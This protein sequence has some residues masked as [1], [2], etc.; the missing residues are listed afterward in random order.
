MESES[1]GRP[2]SR[3]SKEQRHNGQVSLLLTL[4]F[5]YIVFL[6]TFDPTAVDPSHLV[7]VNYFIGGRKLGIS[8]VGSLVSC[9]HSPSLSDTVRVPS[10]ALR[11]SNLHLIDVAHPYVCPSVSSF[12]SKNLCLRPSRRVCK[13]CFSS[14]KMLCVSAGIPCLIFHLSQLVTFIFHW[15]PGVRQT[16]LGAVS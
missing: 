16:W 5:V 9:T 1:P 7:L 10:P 14:L 2:V 4:I 11:K 12:W 15:W 8:Q 13:I 6:P 3:H